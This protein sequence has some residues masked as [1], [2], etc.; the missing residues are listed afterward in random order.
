[1][2]KNFTTSLLILLGITF[3][4]QAQE[5]AKRYVLLEQFTNTRCG[6]CAAK[7]PAFDTNIL[8]EYEDTE[9]LHI[10]YHPKV[11]YSTDIFYQANKEEMDARQSYYSV[12]GTPRVFIAGELAPNGSELLPVSTLEPHLGQESAVSLTIKE[13]VDNDL[14]LVTINVDAVGNLPEGDWVLRAVVVEKVVDYDAPNGLTKHRN[15]FRRALNGWDG[16]AISNNSSTFEYEYKIDPSQLVTEQVYVIAFIQQDA[17]KEVL[18]AGSSWG[19]SE[20]LST[21]ETEVNIQTSTVSFYPNPVRSEK[22]HFKAQLLKPEPINIQLF[23]LVG[24]KVMD[25]TFDDAKK[26]TL[27]LSKLSTGIYYATFESGD[28]STTRKIVKAR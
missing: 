19:N 21:E 25:E 15:V 20:V 22:L 2:I 4:L 3:A 7:D 5:T 9:V 26:G 13:E 23:D 10:G 27:D 24:Q 28:F 12:Q 6:A 1:M 8:D 16:D 17:T 11:P 14:H 18:N